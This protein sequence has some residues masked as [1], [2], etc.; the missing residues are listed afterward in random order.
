MR[1]G[2]ILRVAAVVEGEA[3][4]VRD[5]VDPVARGILVAPVEV[6]PV[7]EMDVAAG[8]LDRI[9]E[10]GAH[11]AAVVVAAGIC[12]K[13]ERNARGTCA[14]DLDGARSGIVLHADAQAGG[15]GA[16]RRNRDRDGVVGDKVC[17]EV[18]GVLRGVVRVYRRSGIARLG[19]GPVR[20]VVPEAVAGGAVPE[21]VIGLRVNYCGHRRKTHNTARE[22]SY[23]H[24]ILLKIS[25]YYTTILSNCQPPPKP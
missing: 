25:V 15:V 11:E 8:Y 13:L 9:G 12:R 21:Q 23:R 19:R 7:A 4:A 18:D 6:E 10:R 3:V 17:V 20:R 14:D 24:S 2:G 5:R 16:V 1:G 22:F